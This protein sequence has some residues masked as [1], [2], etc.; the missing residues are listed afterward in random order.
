MTAEKFLADAKKLILMSCVVI[1]EHMKD[2]E[3]IHSTTFFSLGIERLLKFVLA[4]INPVF[5]LSNGDFKNAVPI[6]YKHRF[7]NN[8]EYSVVSSKPNTD[9]V[10][11]RVAMQRALIFSSGVNKNRQLLHSLANY[12]DIIAHRPLSE[13]DI[14]KANHLLAKDGYKLVNDICSERSL[15]V[16]EFFGTDHDRLHKLSKKLQNIEDFSREMTELLAEHKALWLKRKSQSAFIE[17]TI[18][19]TH[20]L[21][22]HNFNY[23]SFT[24]PA[25]EQEAVAKIEPDYDYDEEGTYMTGLFVDSI[26]CHFCDLELQDYEELNYVNANSIFQGSHD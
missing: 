1:K 20:S 17:K 23:E 5:V 24:C 13:L 6:L 21:L 4:E 11:F 14:A 15:S 7:V 8:E 3:V 2:L 9:F 18:I 22:D 19:K 25:C 26:N 10:S 12:R 16:Q